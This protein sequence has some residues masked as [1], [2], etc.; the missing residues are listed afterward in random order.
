MPNPTGV[1]PICFE[2]SLQSHLVRI[3]PVLFRPCQLPPFLEV[4]AHGLVLDQGEGERD[5]YAP[6]QLRSRDVS[7]VNH[8]FREQTSIPFSCALIQIDRGFQPVASE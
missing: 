5:Q 6:V 1:A 8:R 7:L 3:E 2:R 4:C